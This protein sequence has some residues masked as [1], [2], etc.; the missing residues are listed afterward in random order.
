MFES[1]QNDVAPTSLHASGKSRLA[2]QI[3]AVLFDMD[4]VLI[5]AKG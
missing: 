2:S 1:T 4:G 3:K 5:Q